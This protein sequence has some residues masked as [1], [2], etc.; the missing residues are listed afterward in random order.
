MAISNFSNPEEDSPWICARPSEEINAR[1]LQKGCQIMLS[2]FG[3]KDHEYEQRRIS[4]WWQSKRTCEISNRCTNVSN[5]Q[6]YFD[7]M[8]VLKLDGK[9]S[10]DH[11]STSGI[12]RISILFQRHRFWKL[13][14][15]L[16]SR[17]QWTEIFLTNG[18]SE[19]TVCVNGL[20][21]WDELD[22]YAYLWNNNIRR[23]SRNDTS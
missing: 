14:V 12:L 10:V 8:V 5:L 22:L 3:L 23:P 18:K 13:L 16:T 17:S 11:D 1:S 20:C 2:S 7:S 4:V 6:G 21:G 15:F 9:L 19:K